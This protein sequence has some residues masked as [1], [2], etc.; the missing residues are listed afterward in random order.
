VA[1][2]ATRNSSIL[3]IRTVEIS[4]IIMAM[5]NLVVEEPPNDFCTAISVCVH[6]WG[7]RV[8]LLRAAA[9]Y[10]ADK[11]KSALQGLD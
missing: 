9:G 6:A 1:P 10:D 11:R 2:H 7:V 5:F 8:V 3:L 4:A